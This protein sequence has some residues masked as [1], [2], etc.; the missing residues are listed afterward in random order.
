MNI[1]LDRAADILAQLGNRTRLQIIR[2]LVKAGEHGVPVGDIQS[3][4]GVPAST[5]SHH[6]HY[7]RNVELISQRREGTVRYCAMN[8]P[9]MD[10]I[11]LFLTDQCCIDSTPDQ[12]VK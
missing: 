10:A 9:M 3:A 11:V 7:L 5:L 4:L 8:Y 12:D 1:D 6:L 2:H